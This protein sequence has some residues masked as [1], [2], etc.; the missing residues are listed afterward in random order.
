M[1]LPR[2]YYTVFEMRYRELIGEQKK[3]AQA[4]KE[5]L[6]S[7]K[8]SQLQSTATKNTITDYK[9]ELGV[10]VISYFN[11]AL[12]FHDDET[13]NK[14]KEF[15]LPSNVL[16]WFVNLSHLEEQ[17]ESIRRND[18]GID[19]FTGLRLITGYLN[20]KFKNE[21]LMHFRT[22]IHDN[23]RMSPLS[24][25]IIKARQK[26]RYY[27]IERE[28]KKN[29]FDRILNSQINEGTRVIESLKSPKNFSRFARGNTESILLR[30]F[31]EECFDY[32]EKALTKTKF[33]SIIYDLLSLL[34][35]DRV[36][37][38][39]NQFL[40]SHKRTYQSY[41]NFDAYKAKKIRSILF[42]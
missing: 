22:E 13:L 29:T 42:T 26:R 14:L 27:G 37:I 20:T 7:Y 36:F 33:L 8:P 39:E 21:L 28:P 35:L 16:R 12:F 6:L 30:I 25:E 23:V 4:A 38:T 19:T 1:N 10:K 41:K 18:I 3:L 32:D 2:A 24:K 17:F 11:D 9:L 5:R 40:N 15:K 34:I 31:V